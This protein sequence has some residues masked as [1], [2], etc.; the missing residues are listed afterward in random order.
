M[1]EPCEYDDCGAIGGFVTDSRPT[2]TF[3][4]AIRRR[5]QCEACGH[6]WTTFEIASA[7]I[8]RFDYLEARIAQANTAMRSI[9]R[10]SEHGVN[11]TNGDAISSPQGTGHE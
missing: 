5:R 6:R 1:S 4:G 2:S 8:E 11:L 10:L 7:H 3:G 9:A